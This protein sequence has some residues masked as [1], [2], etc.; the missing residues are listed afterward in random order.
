MTFLKDVAAQREA[1]ESNKKHGASPEKLRNTRIKCLNA[2]KTEPPR[3]VVV[4]K[5]VKPETKGFTISEIHRLMKDCQT[6][7]GDQ[8]SISIRRVSS[9]H[10]GVHLTVQGALQQHNKGKDQK[11]HPNTRVTGRKINRSDALLLKSFVPRKRKTSSSG[12]LTDSLKTLD[13]CEMGPMEKTRQWLFDNPIGDVMAS[14]VDPFDDVIEVDTALPVADGYAIS[15]TTESRSVRFGYDR[16]IKSGG[17][18]IKLRGRVSRTENFDTWELTVC[19]IG[20]V[21]CCKYFCKNQM[22][23]AW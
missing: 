6:S 13:S 2:P 9:A 1:D 16:I 12:S 14:D 23:K 19:Q 20:Y 10:P 22:E 8:I 15:S 11:L 18:N 17:R 5:K 3:A 7:G 21:C 4:K